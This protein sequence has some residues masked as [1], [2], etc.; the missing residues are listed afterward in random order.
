MEDCG[1]KGDQPIL[2]EKE[3]PGGETHRDTRE[4]GEENELI[5]YQEE[6]AQ[7]YIIQGGVYSANVTIRHCAK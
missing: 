5:Q 2:K 1:E 6:A 4:G 7:V 3:K